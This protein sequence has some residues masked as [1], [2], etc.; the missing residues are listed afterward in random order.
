[1]C[2]VFSSACDFCLESIKIATSEI[3]IFS[4]PQVEGG[5]TDLIGEQ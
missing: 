2:F 5:F 3:M 1:M 4:S